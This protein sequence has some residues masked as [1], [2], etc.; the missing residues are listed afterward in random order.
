MFLA[1][2]AAVAPTILGGLLNALSEGLRAYDSI[3]EE[4]L[5]L[6]R[7]AS[8]AMWSIACETAFG[9][10]EGAFLRCFAETAAVAAEGILSD[11]PVATVFLQFMEDKDKWEGPASELLKGMEA[12][13]RRPLRVA[14]EKLQLT[15]VTARNKNDPVAQKKLAAAISDC[16]DAQAHLGATVH[17]KDWPTIPN[18]LSRRLRS[19]DTQLRGAGHI[20]RW[21]TAHRGGRKI[22]VEKITRRENTEYDAAASNSS[23]SSSSAYKNMETSSSSEEGEDDGY[24]PN[25]GRADPDDIPF[26]EDEVDYP[27][28]SPD[29]R[30]ASLDRKNTP[31]LHKD[32]ERKGFE[33]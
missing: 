32:K 27:A 29:R 3:V 14:E 21:P 15:R 11:S 8:F 9:W 12:L 17:H 10:P 13:A 20:I 23:S 6:P 33:I 7:L 1:K 25:S 4:D 26:I 19:L 22:I 2:F 5:N 16:K 30:S 18:A 31:G 24:R 28:P